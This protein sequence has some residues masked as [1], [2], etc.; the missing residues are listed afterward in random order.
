M[1]NR[2]ETV[3]TVFRKISSAQNRRRRTCLCLTLG[4]GILVSRI[5]EN[6]GNASAYR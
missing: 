3:L 1:R 2:A 4:M 5:R 6:A